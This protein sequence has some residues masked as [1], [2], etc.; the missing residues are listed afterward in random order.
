M[1]NV[2]YLVSIMV[3]TELTQLTCWEVLLRSGK[4]ENQ[5]L[6]LNI[7]VAIHTDTLAS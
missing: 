4:C 3:L 2:V 5:A 7:S 6:Q 1:S